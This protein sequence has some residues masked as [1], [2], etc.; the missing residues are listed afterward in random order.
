M[1][2]HSRGVRCIPAGLAAGGRKKSFV[3]S[4]YPNTYVPEVPIYLCPSL[5]D[6]VHLY[7]YLY[8]YLYFYIYLPI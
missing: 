8:T 3:S 2:P 5:S 7:I 4:V 6:S 1:A